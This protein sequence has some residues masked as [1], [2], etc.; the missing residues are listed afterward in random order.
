MIVLKSD[1]SAWDS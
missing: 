1:K